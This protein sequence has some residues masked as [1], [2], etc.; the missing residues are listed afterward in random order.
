MGKL[1]EVSSHFRQEVWD[2]AEDNKVIIQYEG[3]V[4]IPKDNPMDCWYIPDT[5]RAVLFVLR[6]S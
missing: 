6:W 2:W 5:D 4:N 1:V 3:T